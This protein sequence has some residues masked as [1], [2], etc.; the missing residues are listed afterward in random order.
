ME[1]LKG[2]RAG[3]WAAG[4]ESSQHS[5]QQDLHKGALWVGPA[6]GPAKPARRGSLP[7]FPGRAPHPL[8][9]LHPQPSERE[10][11]QLALL[12]Y[13]PSVS[14]AGRAASG[15]K[16]VPGL[17][18]EEGVAQG[19]QEMPGGRSRGVQRS[20]DRSSAEHRGRLIR[21][22]VRR[23]PPLQTAWVPPSLQGGAVGRGSAYTRGC[24]GPLIGLARQGQGEQRLE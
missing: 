23:S 14:G 22:S 2:W 12:D 20:L 3:P 7:H 17:G 9:Y 19:K 24:W 5:R 13:L 1:R 11:A 8:S 15:R 4:G 21:T 18:A 10:G 6:G 16:G